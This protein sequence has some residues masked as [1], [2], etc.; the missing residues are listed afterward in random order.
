MNVHDLLKHNVTFT[1]SVTKAY[2]SD[3]TEDEML[4]FAMAASMEQHK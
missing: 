2:V 1:H 4:A 3:M